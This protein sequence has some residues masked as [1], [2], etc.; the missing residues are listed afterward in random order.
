MRFFWQKRDNEVSDNSSSSSTSSASS[1]DILRSTLSSDTVDSS[2]ALNIPAFYACVNKIADTIAS[3][4][5]KLFRKTGSDSVEELTDD[6][7]VF[8]LNSDTKDTVNAHDMKKLMVSDMFV[9]KGG[10]AYINGNIGNIRSLNYID[11]NNI[12]F[13]NNTDPIFKDYVVNVAGSSAG[14][15]FE[16]FKFIKLLNN[17]SNGYEGKSMIETCNEILAISSSTQNF[18]KNSVKTGGNKKGFLK[19]TTRLSKESMNSLKNAFRELYSNS[20]EN[21]V[22]LNDGLD[23]KESSNTSVELQLSENKKA[24]SD[25][26]CNIFGIPP[27]ILRGGATETDRKIYIESVIFPI[28]TNFENA[29]NTVLLTEDEKKD[30]FFKFDINNLIKGDIDKRYS[31]YKIAL[32]SGFMQIDEVRK[33]E[34]LPSFKLDFIKLG[35]KDVLYYPKDNKV[36]TPNTNF[37]YDIDDSNSSLG[38]ND[39]TINNGNVNNDNNNL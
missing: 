4:D 33:I 11:A 8:L 16:G 23:F 28:I 7:R 35:L 20:T 26:I 1:N 39:G 15:T 10:Y 19:S 22:I 6:E 37:L 31:A 27:S 24:N 34:N 17:S 5:V 13:Q 18:E 3:L 9:K 38:H 14:T 30:H 36:Y 32:D 29:L 21:V 25:F 2:T 12:S